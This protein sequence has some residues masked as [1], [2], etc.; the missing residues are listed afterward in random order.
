MQ[1]ITI[2]KAMDAKVMQIYKQ[3]TELVEASIAIKVMTE[4][5][6]IFYES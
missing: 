6:F 4:Y 3:T 1:I 2:Q 5:G